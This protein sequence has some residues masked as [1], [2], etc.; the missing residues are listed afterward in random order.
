MKAPYRDG[1]VGQPGLFNPVCNFKQIGSNW[2]MKQMSCIFTSLHLH[3]ISPPARGLAHITMF[4]YVFFFFA[5][6]LVL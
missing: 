5:I 1:Y 3:R 2:L 6:L 4:S